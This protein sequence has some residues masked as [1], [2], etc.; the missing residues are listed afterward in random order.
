MHLETLHVRCL[1][2]KESLLGGIFKKGKV[3]LWL[4]VNG[5]ATQWQATL[6]LWRRQGLF[7]VVTVG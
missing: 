4:E 1:A 5:S 2:V 3:Y 7:E 6:A